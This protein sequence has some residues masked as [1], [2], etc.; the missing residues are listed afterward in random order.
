[1]LSF[2]AG[3]V[4]T[5]HAIDPLRTMSQY[6]RDR[7]NANN[8]FPKGPIYSIAQTRDGYLWI[9]AENGLVRFDGTSFRLMQSSGPNIPAV[10]HVLGLL[11]DNDGSL[12]VRM[13]RP[14]LLRYRE[15]AFEDAMKA[16][17]RP[18]A[19]V[20]AM[21]RSADGTLLLWVLE[22]EGH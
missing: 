14:T 4:R 9:G 13:R 19:N 8:G 20:T 16:F 12:W 7:W 2:I 17:G 15:G 11:A 10:S 6:V 21:S 18:S 22:N 5:A 1:M 3:T